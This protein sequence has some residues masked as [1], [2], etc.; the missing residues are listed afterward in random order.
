MSTEHDTRHDRAKL[1]NGRAESTT[2]MSKNLLA[3]IALALALVFTGSVMVGQ[4]YWNPDA[5]AVSAVA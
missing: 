3:G 5:A 2:R 4:E 1:P